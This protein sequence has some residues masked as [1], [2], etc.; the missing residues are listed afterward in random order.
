MRSKF[1]YF[2]G[3]HP[4]GFF[5]LIL[6]TLCIGFVALGT[7]Q[8][9][10]SV[11]VSLQGRVSGQDEEGNSVGVIANANVEILSEDNSHAGTARTYETGFYQITG[12][13]PGKYLY[14]VSADGYTSEDAGRGVSIP[15]GGDGFVL[16]FILTKGDLTP[17]PTGSLSGQVFVEKDGERTPG[18][19]ARIVASRSVGTIVV[20]RS[21]DEEGNYALDLPVGEWKMSAILPDGLGKLTVRQF[22]KYSVKESE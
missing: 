8:E 13:Q 18:L 4:T 6:S 20:E 2:N 10:A 1:D 14:R 17:P 16:D 9:S 22:L 12:L 15:E 3:G 21:V 11:G 7:A 19:G 5:R